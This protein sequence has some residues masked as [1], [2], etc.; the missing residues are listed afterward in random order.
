MSQAFI[1]C[2]ETG[3]P[4][5]VG[6]NFEWLQLDSVDIG[7]ETI[8]CRQC[9]QSHAWTRNDLNLRSDGGG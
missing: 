1:N 5:Y 7:E 4:I 8:D 3:R 6:Y 9:G 2:P